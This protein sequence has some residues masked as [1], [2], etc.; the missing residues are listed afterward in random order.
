[1]GR[2][3]PL[4]LAERKKQGLVMSRALVFGMTTRDVAALAGL[5]QNGAW[6]HVAN[7]VDP[8]W[9][10][11][12]DPPT[13]VE[14]FR[15]YRALRTRQNK[16]AAKRYHDRRHGI[17]VGQVHRSAPVRRSL[18]SL[19]PID[20]VVE[21]GIE[22]GP[23]TTDEYGS[24]TDK[25]KADIVRERL[26]PLGTVVD[27]RK[28]P[29]AG[30]DFVWRPTQ[31]PQLEIPVEVKPAGARVELS[32]S[33]NKRLAEDPYYV[34]ALVSGSGVRWLCRSDLVFNRTTTTYVYDVR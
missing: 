23:G 34:I 10:G 11:E 16:A 29:N 31:H 32:E 7:N 4:T 30:C 24:R 19:L 17:P 18:R 33:Q 5:S 25:S 28:V 8:D 14:T 2:A 12:Q 1:M 27:V 21:A 3:R 26:E 13:V 22:Y 15:G 9:T 6:N 20:E